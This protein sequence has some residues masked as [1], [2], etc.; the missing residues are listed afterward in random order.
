[1]ACVGPSARPIDVTRGGSIPRR[2]A[3]PSVA[4]A[5]RLVR[6]RR[7]APAGGGRYVELNP[8]RAG[9]DSCGKL[10]AMEQRRGA[11]RGR[12]DWSPSLHCSGGHE[13]GS[14]SEKRPSQKKTQE[15]LRFHEQP[16]GRWEI[17]RFGDSRRTRENPEKPKNPAPRDGHRIRYGVPGTHG[18]HEGKKS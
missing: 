17:R 9:R 14:F 10:V 1:M 5:V 6:H 7:A 8:V 16:A 11:W 12:D 3:R 15:L 18:T 13:L 2:V 4:R